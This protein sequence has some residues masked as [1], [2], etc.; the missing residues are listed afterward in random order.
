MSREW[1]LT[2]TLR[3]RRGFRC[4]SRTKRWC[5]TRPG[6]ESFARRPDGLQT[7]TSGKRRSPRWPAMPAT[8]SPKSL[9][10]LSE[11]GSWCKPETLSRRRLNGKDKTFP[12]S[13]A[14]TGSEGAGNWHHCFKCDHFTPAIRASIPAPTVSPRTDEAATLFGYQVR[15][16]GHSQ[17]TLFLSGWF[18]CGFYVVLV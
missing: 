14:G 5:E 11:H 4:G 7:M 16:T 15:V 8:H 2:A 1:P 12:A 18:L 17:L 10:V 13:E 6:A 9:P 3:A